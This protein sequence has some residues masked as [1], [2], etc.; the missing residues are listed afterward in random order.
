[1]LKI[2]F[3]VLWKIIRAQYCCFYFIFVLQHIWDK[4]INTASWYGEYLVEKLLK[5]S[6][7]V[8]ATQ[9][10][11]VYSC[12]LTIMTS[13]TVCMYCMH[14]CMYCM[15]CTYENK[16]NFWWDQA[17]FIWTLSLLTPT[18]ACFKL[19][20]NTLTILPVLFV[21]HICASTIAIHVCKA[22]QQ[23]LFQGLY[24]Y[25]LYTIIA[26]KRCKL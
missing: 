15:H 22:V 4:H 6:Y 13:F 5:L 16:I 18:L 19:T 1:V 24:F 2:I 25:L 17:G 8:N 10:V 21:W 26:S 20:K 9:W 14:V 23:Q 11:N 12:L 3:W 7:V